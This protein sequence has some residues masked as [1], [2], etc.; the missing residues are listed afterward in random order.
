MECVSQIQQTAMFRTGHVNVI[1]TH[2]PYCMAFGMHYN[3]GSKCHLLLATL[4]AHTC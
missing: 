3:K 4:R 1:F 2:V